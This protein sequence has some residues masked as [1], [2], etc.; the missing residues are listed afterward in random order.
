MGPASGG[1]VSGPFGRPATVALVSTPEALYLAT[2]PGGPIRVLT[3]SAAL[4]WEAALG[5]DVEA[6][7]QRVAEAAGLPPD[8]VRPDVEPFLAQLVELGLLE[9]STPRVSD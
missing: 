3:G 1:V 8:A 2:L 4:I 9:R 7:V 6:A 5:G